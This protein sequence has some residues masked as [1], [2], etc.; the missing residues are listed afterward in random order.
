MVKKVFIFLSLI[1]ILSGC[2]LFFGSPFPS[3]LPF[4]EDMVDLSDKVGDVDQDYHEAYKLHLLNNFIFLTVE[5]QKLVILD[6]KLN[7]LKEY[8]GNYGRLGV[9]SGTSFQYYIGDEEYDTGFAYIGLSVYNANGVGYFD[10]SIGGNGIVVF[11]TDSFLGELVNSGDAA[12]STVPINP[13]MEIRAVAYDDLSTMGYLFFWNYDNEEA[14]VLS[15]DG[16]TL[17]GTMTPLP[18][19]IKLDG[20]DHDPEFHYTRDGYVVT[21]EGRSQ[22]FD[23]A[24]GE[25]K[26]AIYGG[27]VEQFASAYDIDGNT[28][29]YFDGSNKILY[30]CNTW[31]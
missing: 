13:G 27:R 2:A 19:P 1:L 4:V 20:I 15:A 17:A 31:W 8:S 5:D 12:G 21:T 14:Q 9:Y 23:L 28:F 24:S 16:A 29:Y 30:R 18:S 3:H 6:S 22:L 11:Q 26:K 25:E 10:P 7:V